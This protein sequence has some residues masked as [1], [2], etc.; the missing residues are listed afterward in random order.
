MEKNRFEKKFNRLSKYVMESKE[1]ERKMFWA[2]IILY[3][4]MFFNIFAWIGRT[5]IA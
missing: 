2:V 5:F 1:F 3:G 4:Y